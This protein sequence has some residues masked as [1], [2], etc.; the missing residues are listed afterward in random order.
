MGPF[1]EEMRKSEQSWATELIALGIRNQTLEGESKE[2]KE[3]YRRAKIEIS[4]LLTQVSTLEANVQS[5]EMRIGNSQGKA[6][7]ESLGT[8]LAQQKLV[9]LL[10][11]HR[12]AGAGWGL[13]CWCP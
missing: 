9:T 8:V 5:M 2:L 1:D 7:R 11:D 6:E 13:L 4:K 12:R 10:D 3:E